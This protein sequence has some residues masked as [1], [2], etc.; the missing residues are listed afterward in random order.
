VG[1]ILAFAA[2]LLFTVMGFGIDLDE[3]LQHETLN[4]PA[5]YSYTIFA[6]DA[7]M[8]ISLVLMFLQKNRHLCLSCLLGSAFLYAQLLSVYFPLYRCYQSFPFYRFRNAGN[9]S[10]MEV[11]NRNNLILQ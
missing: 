11:L 6:I 10:E 5:W 9:N 7:L 3:Y 1:F 4:I 2:L 8:V